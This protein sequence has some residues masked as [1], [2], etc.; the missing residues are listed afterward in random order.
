MSEFIKNELIASRRGALAI[1]KPKSL[2]S[3]REGKLG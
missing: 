1:R 3:I 2:E